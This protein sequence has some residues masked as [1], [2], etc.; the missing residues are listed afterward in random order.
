MLSDLI[1]EARTQKGI[2]GR[3]ILANN[4][5]ADTDGDGDVDIDDYL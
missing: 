5:V 4:Y 3:E 1:E 2:T